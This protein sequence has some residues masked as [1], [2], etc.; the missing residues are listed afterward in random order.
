MVFPFKSPSSHHNRLESQQWPPWPSLP[1]RSGCGHNKLQFWTRQL[2][3][4]DEGLSVFFL[5]RGTQWIEKDDLNQ[6]MVKH[7]WFDD[8][9]K[10]TRK[11]RRFMVFLGFG[12]NP[13][14]ELYGM[15]LLIRYKNT[16]AQ[17]ISLQGF[18]C[19]AL[20]DAAQARSVAGG[21]S[22]SEA[23]KSAC[24]SRAVCCGQR[25]DSG[26]QIWLAGKSPNWMEVSS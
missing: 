26:N 20:V 19:P 4:A 15:F 24:A 18:S 22:R 13:S 21:R 2:R 16:L 5:C 11:I 25:L 7:R 23:K 1:I 17:M 10:E 12:T 9:Q 8:Q 6:L 3:S 14:I